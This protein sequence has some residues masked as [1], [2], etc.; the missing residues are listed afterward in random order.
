[1]KLHAIQ[2]YTRLHVARKSTYKDVPIGPTIEAESDR[3]WSLFHQ[4]PRSSFIMHMSCAEHAMAIFGY[5][6]ASSNQRLYWLSQ[7]P[8]DY[9]S[10]I[11]G[12]NFF[13]NYVESL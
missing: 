12:R 1:M 9:G 5:T 11:V 6:C 10:F 4:F 3:F 13:L 8:T 7:V 2:L